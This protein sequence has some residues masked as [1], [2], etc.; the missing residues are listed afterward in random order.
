LK[1]QYGR[2]AV[3]VELGNGQSQEFPLAQIGDNRE[4]LNFIKERE[5]KRMETLDATLEEVFIEVTGK[6]LKG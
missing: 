2:E 6:S 1:H 3:N 4:F 5:V